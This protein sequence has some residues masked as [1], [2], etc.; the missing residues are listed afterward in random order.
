MV[1][2][3]N[4]MDTSTLFIPISK[5]DDEKRMVYGYATTESVDSQNEIV[6]LDAVKEALP[7]YLKYA[8]IREMHQPSAVGKAVD[9]SFDE[10]GMYL[11]AKVVDDAA[12]TKV[13]EGVYNGYSIGGAILNK[14]NGSVNKLKLTEISLVDRPSNPDTTFTMW[15]MDMED[16]AMGNLEKRNFSE[17]QRQTMAS[18]GQALP[19]GS[20]PIASVSDLENAIHA[21]GRAKDPAKVKAHIIARAKA[22][23]ATDKLPD[24]WMSTQKIDM[25][26]MVKAD[27]DEPG[28]QAEAAAESQETAQD[29]ENGTVGETPSHLVPETATSE[30]GETAEAEVISDNS[31]KTDTQEAVGETPQEGEETAQEGEGAKNPDKEASEDAST[32]KKVAGMLEKGEMPADDDIVELLKA[33]GITPT[34]AI[35]ANAKWDFASQILDTVAKRITTQH[36][37]DAQLDGLKKAVENQPKGTPTG[38]I[39]LLQK[40]ATQLKSLKKDYDGIA[41]GDGDDDADD[42]Y[43][44][45]DFATN[46]A[47]AQAMEELPDLLS[48]YY[49]TICS[50]VFCDANQASKA[51]LLRNSADQ[52]V[53]TMTSEANM[54]LS[55]NAS[56]LQ[57]AGRMISAANQKEIDSALASLQAAVAVLARFSGQGAALTPG[58]QDKLKSGVSIGSERTSQIV[59]GA[60]AIEALK[61]PQM[62]LM[63]RPTDLAKMEETIANLQA[64]L[65]KFENLPAPMKAKAFVVEKFETQPTARELSESLAKADNLHNEL[66]KDPT[67]QLL[68]QQAHELSAKIQRLQRDSRDARYQ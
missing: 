60:N 24:G 31:E 53:S 16:D 45:R 61:V 55:E 67:N 51:T 30:P 38:Y 9:I 54:Y 68:Q 8:N 48:I 13:K 65:E 56:S 36:D 29:G 39:L 2:T 17:K 19:D 43:T 33:Q 15:K 57:K 26:E 35:V 3:I 11:G 58:E 46:M 12:W 20:Y 42:D 5:V 41:V 14:V 10:K 49:N 1:A 21:Y 44:P 52:F 50:I 34:D 23:G 64:R 40:L 25:P 62:G 7:D 37:L 6:K 66:V 18:N 22:L 47:H 4:L 27:S 59:Q 63:D 32:L 28:N